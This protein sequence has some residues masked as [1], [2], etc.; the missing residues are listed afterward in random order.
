LAYSR[1]TVS[2]FH[3]HRGLALGI[4]L[5]G[6]GLGA[7]LVPTFLVPFI[8]AHGW[9][10]GYAALAMTS[11]LAILPVWL[12]LRGSIDDIGS[13]RARQSVMPMVRKPEFAVLAAMFFL[14]AIAILG[15]VVQFVPMLSGFGLSPVA[16][17]SLSGLIGMSAV[18]G[19]LA[20]GALLDRFE[21]ASITRLVF[22]LAGLGL[23]LLAWGGAQMALP[24]ALLLGLGIGAEVH[25]LSFH[26][27]RI[28]P[29]EMFGQINGLLYSVF[30]VGSGLG[31]ALSGVLFD[32]TGSYRASLLIFGIA[33]IG[34][35]LFTFRLSAASRKFDE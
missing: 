24:T 1:L 29:R 33:L 14:A 19:R 6:T 12:L 18:M 4:A 32:V 30:L 13:A 31:P 17:G 28:F 23:W 27:A 16:V 35:A 7:M 21:A 20:I 8:T 25:L 5:S 15:T 11:L 26:T 10:Q 22:I 2:T 34:A 3:Q 9:R